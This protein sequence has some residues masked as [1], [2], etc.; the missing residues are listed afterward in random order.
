M[1]KVLAVLHKLEDLIKQGTSS[2]PIVDVAKDVGIS[3]A[4]MVAIINSSYFQILYLELWE[5]TFDVDHND[6]VQHFILNRI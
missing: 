4:E 6:E 5:C 3:D 2:V 1:S